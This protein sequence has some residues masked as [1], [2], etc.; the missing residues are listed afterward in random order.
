MAVS[1]SKL[2]GEGM[3]S[4][5]HS[6]ESGVVLRRENPPG[7]EGAIKPKGKGQSPESEDKSHGPPRFS[8]TSDGFIS[9]LPLLG[10]TTADFIPGLS[11][12]GFPRVWVGDGIGQERSI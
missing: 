8:S 2:E 11:S 10:L 6:L 3:K 5:A 12:S 1:G 4:Q 7:K 9:Y